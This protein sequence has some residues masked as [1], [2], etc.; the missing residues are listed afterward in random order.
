MESTSE[1]V[2]PKVLSHAVDGYKVT[3]QIGCEVIG[4]EGLRPNQSLTIFSNDSQES[5]FEIPLTVLTSKP[6]EFSV[7]SLDFGRINKATTKT[8]VLKTQAESEIES[9]K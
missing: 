4:S 2:V 6:I 3:Y 9:L 8:V 1:N 7:D 5:K